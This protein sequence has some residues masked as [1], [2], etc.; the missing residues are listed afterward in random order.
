MGLPEGCEHHYG[1]NEGDER[2]G[3]A[4]SVDLSERRE[5]TRLETESRERERERVG[6]GK[7]ECVNREMAS[8]VKCHV[9]CG[10]H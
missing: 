10:S 3:V 8:F 9:N 2:R 4:H 1:C 6:D 5:V 7:R